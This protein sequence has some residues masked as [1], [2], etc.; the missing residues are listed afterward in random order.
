MNE[1][2]LFAIFFIWIIVIIYFLIGALFNCLRNEVV[3]DVV[4]KGFDGR[5]KTKRVFKYICEVILSHPTTGIDTSKTCLTLELIHINEKSAKTRLSTID[6]NFKDAQFN[7]GICCEIDI[8]GFFKIIR[9][10]AMPPI[11][12]IRAV[13]NGSK[14]KNFL[15][16]NKSL[17]F[18]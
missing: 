13:H 6:M 18:V 15:L 16:R 7:R 4:Q 2:I 8:R 10:K 17:A 3:T 11:T 9:N 1:P 5:D 14:G 12:H